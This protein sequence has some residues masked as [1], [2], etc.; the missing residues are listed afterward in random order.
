MRGKRGGDYSAQLAAL[1][2]LS[3]WRIPGEAL[4]LQHISYMGPK[5]LADAVASSNVPLRVLEA[6]L[7]VLGAA[8]PFMRRSLDPIIRIASIVLANQ[9]KLPPHI[10]RDFL[11][12]TDQVG[13]NPGRAHLDR[14]GFHLPVRR[15]ADTHN[16]NAATYQ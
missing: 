1:I 5:A 2:A 13:R 7:G 4:D 11:S 10:A 3:G 6:C 12:N 8:S 15:Y 9:E 14:R 16:Q